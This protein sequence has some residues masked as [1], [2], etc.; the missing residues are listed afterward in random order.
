M[1]ELLYVRPDYVTR[2]DD[3]PTTLPDAHRAM[4][5]ALSVGE[6]LDVPYGVMLAASNALER[7]ANDVDADERRFTVD[8]VAML[9][10]ALVEIRRQLDAAIDRDN[11]PRGTG[12]DLI[13]REAAQPLELDSGETDFDRVFQFEDDGRV[14]AIYPRMSIADLMETLPNLVG[15][16]RNAASRNLEVALIEE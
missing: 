1:K 3:A 14:G 11:F 9:A 5:M 15:F 10:E 4:R 13:K 12:G 6:I 7:A 2:G 8:E 16:F